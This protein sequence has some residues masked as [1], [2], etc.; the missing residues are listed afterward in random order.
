MFDICPTL[1]NLATMMKSGQWS[2]NFGIITAAAAHLDN[3]QFIKLTC[4]LGRNIRI[5]TPDPGSHDGYHQLDDHG[6]AGVNILQI[7]MDLGLTIFRISF[8]RKFSTHILT[9]YSPLR[10]G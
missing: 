6:Q 7:I 1:L 3:I 9:K 10:A 5:V 2:D 4:L 8:K